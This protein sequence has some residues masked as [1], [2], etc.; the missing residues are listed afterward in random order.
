M[1]RSLLVALAVGFLIVRYV[2]RE[3]V[4]KELSWSGG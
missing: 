1:A 3:F 2:I 4:R